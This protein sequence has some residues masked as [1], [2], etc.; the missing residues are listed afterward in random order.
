MDGAGD[1][2]Y[3]SFCHFLP[4]FARLN[5]FWQ[6]IFETL[7]FSKICL[8]PVLDSVQFSHAVT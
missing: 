1:L 4:T 7:F 3:F 2:F 6:K 8:S 5:K